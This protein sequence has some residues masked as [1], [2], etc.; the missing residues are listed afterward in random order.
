MSIINVHSGGQRAKS[1]LQWLCPHFTFLLIHS[2]SSSAS[3]GSSSLF[4]QYLCWFMVGAV[5]DTRGL[6]MFH[7]FPNG[8]CLQRLDLIHSLFDIVEGIHIMNIV[9]RC[10]VTSE[11]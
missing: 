10:H 2:F 7:H 5:S 11:G 6:T 8:P 9:I 1:T 4:S 3:S